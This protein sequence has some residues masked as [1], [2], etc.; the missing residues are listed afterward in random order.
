MS[1]GFG[2]GFA[3]TNGP[4]SLN[5]TGANPSLGGAN[6]NSDS[7]VSGDEIGTKGMIG[8]ENTMAWPANCG[9]KTSVRPGGLKIETFFKIPVAKR[10]TAKS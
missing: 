6:C 3:S 9:T 1:S 4:C 10:L 2:F 7:V 8:G 5:S